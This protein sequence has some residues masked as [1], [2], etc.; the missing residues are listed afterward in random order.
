MAS[1]I[2]KPRFTCPL[3]GALATVNALPQAVAIL[4]SSQGCGG[5]SNGAILGAA[6]HLGSG[7]CGGASVPA[8]SISEKQIVFGGVA[9]LEEQLNSTR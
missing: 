2:E 3:G 4:H 9:R 5:N 1:F 6:G 7:Y 8:S